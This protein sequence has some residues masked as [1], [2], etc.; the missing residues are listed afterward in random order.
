MEPSELPY[1]PTCLV[2]TKTNASNGTI[3]ITLTFSKPTLTVK[4]VEFNSTMYISCG[5]HLLPLQT[6]LQ[7]R[8][9]IETDAGLQVTFGPDWDR[10][11]LIYADLS[12][13]AFATIMCAVEEAIEDNNISKD[14]SHWLE[15]ECESEPELDTP[16]VLDRIIPPPNPDTL[17]TP[18]A[19]VLTV[20]DQVSLAIG[21][22]A[23]IVALLHSVYLAVQYTR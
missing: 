11:T 6:F 9:A 10:I 19:T 16:S 23:F 1:E 7:V 12:A 17:P 2:S 15:G 3:T 8:N 13:L 21:L 4:L 14:T 18:H 22:L 20:T 5:P